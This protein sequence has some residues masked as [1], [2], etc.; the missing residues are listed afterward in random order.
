MKTELRI[1]GMGCSHCI[2]VVKGI[3][4]Q[5]AVRDIEVELGRAVFTVD[6]ADSLQELVNRIDEQGYHV[7]EAVTR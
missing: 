6:G 2:R 7:V 4:E 3:L 1:E 5:A